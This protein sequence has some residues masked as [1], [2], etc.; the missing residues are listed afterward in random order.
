MASPAPEGETFTA[1]ALIPADLLSL[2]TAEEIEAYLASEL[3]RR[4]V[5]HPEYQRM[6]RE[7]EASLI[8]GNGR[9]ETRGIIK[10]MAR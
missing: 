9:Y 1:T 5:A 6:L 10:S 7:A 3:S 4:I 2:Y 8:R